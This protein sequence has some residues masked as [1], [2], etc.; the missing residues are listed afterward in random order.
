MREVESVEP[1]TDGLD[2]RGVGVRV[3]AAVTPLR[4]LAR[5][6]RTPADIAD[7]SEVRNPENEKGVLAVEIESL[8]GQVREMLDRDA[9]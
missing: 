1:L 4:R 2:D 9:P 8:Q 3:E 7:V 6:A 5:L